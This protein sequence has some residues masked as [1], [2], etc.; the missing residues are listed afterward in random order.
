MAPSL[1]RPAGGTYNVR[2]IADDQP[3]S[4]SLSDLDPKF[5][6][7]T[8]E[9]AEHL[10]RAG[11]E[12]AAEQIEQLDLYRRLLWSWNER[13]NLTRHTTLEKF[14]NRDVFDSYQL[15][16][17][18]E[19][20]ERVL[21]VG[22]GGGVPGVVLA[23]LRPDVAVSLSESTQKKA[24]AVEAMVKEIGLRVPV[25]ATRAEEVLQIATFD[26][27]VARALAALSKV[28][29]SLSPYWDAFDR[30]LLIKGPAWVQE[31]ADAKEQGLLRK[32]ELR[33]AASYQNP[34]TGAESVILSVSPKSAN[35]G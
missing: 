3:G 15:S 11:V 4:T 21:D 2:I 9:L 14:V 34:G 25:H 13:M 33:K 17:L 22:T 28:L 8:N 32:L 30:L 18:L 26:T 7:Q 10:S 29:A 1:C 16:L 27:L 31:R 23:I 20:N 5:E 24:R 12:L 35:G 19:R 6:P